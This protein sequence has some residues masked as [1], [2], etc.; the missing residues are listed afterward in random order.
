MK[1]CALFHPL[2]HHLCSLLCFKFGC[3]ESGF[4]NLPT[5]LLMLH[6]VKSCCWD[7]W[8]CISLPISG[9]HSLP[10]SS[11]YRNWHMRIVWSGGP[12]VLSLKIEL[13]DWQC[14]THPHRDDM[15]PAVWSA[16]RSIRH[17]LNFHVLL[18]T[19]IVIM[20]YPKSYPFIKGIFQ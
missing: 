1:L 15:W 13:H 3:K 14:L 6:C 7:T 16:V 5:T 2:H 20:Y 17:S 9:L 11:T 4:A 10:S 19:Q 18:H 8:W 12:T